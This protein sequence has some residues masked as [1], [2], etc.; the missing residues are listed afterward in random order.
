M[1]AISLMAGV[2]FFGALA[3]P[4]VAAAANAYTTGNVNSRAGP[5]VNFPRVSTLPA[6]V[7]VTIHGCLS[8]LG[9]CDTS[10]RGQRGWVSGRYLEY[11]YNERRVLVGEYGRRIGVPIISFQFG[12]YWDRYYSD[13]PWYRDRPRWRDRWEHNDWNWREDDDNR[14]RRSAER[15]RDDDDGEFRRR[16][17]NDEQVLTG[18]T[19]RLA[20]DSERQER[21]RRSTERGAN[22]DVP[23]GIRRKGGDFCPPGLAKQGRCVQQ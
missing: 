16:R 14:R 20:E 8:D 12:N 18:S 3:A 5:S 21:R 10:W 15:S 22:E 13:R 9:W 11:L 19:R 2:A 1:K 6:G 23:R 17:V 7:A 4:G